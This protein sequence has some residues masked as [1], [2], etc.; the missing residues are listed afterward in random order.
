MP[1]IHCKAESKLKWTKDFVLAAVGVNNVDA[2]SNN[3]NFTIKDTNL[4]VPI[5][6]LSAKYNQKLSKLLSKGF[7]RSVYWNK[8]ETKSEN[9]NMRN[10]F[11]YFVESNFLGVNRL[12]V[13]VYLNWNNDIKRSNTFRCYIPKGIIKNYNVI[14]N[15]KNFHD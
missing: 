11:R 9:K 1:L 14:V 8:Y 6:T 2:D 3:I 15:G 13:L 10:K 5:L 7:K 4:Y 12:F